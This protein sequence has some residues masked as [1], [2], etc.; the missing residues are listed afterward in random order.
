MKCLLLAAPLLLAPLVRA[1]VRVVAPT[2]APYAEIQAA[3][4]AASDGDVVLVKSGTYASFVIRNLSVAIVAD[5]GAVVDVEGSIRVS[6]VAATRTVVLAG[7]RATGTI[8]GS[9]STRHG[10]FARNCAGSLR[11][12]GCT[13]TG[14]P[15]NTG[16]VL[17]PSSHYPSPLPACYEGQGAYLEGC[18]DVALAGCA[19]SGSSAPATSGYFGHGTRPWAGI[20]DGGHGLY[21]VGS[22]V[23]VYDSTLQG[24][25]SGLGPAWGSGA[26]DPLPSDPLGYLGSAGEGL[27]ASSSF[28]FASSATLLGAA[29]WDMSCLDQCFCERPS[30][31]GNALVVDAPT[32]PAF[33]L[34]CV[35][36]P[37]AGGAG[38]GPFP[39]ACTCGIGG[40]FCPANVPAAPAGLASAGPVSTWS[41]FGRRVVL[42]TVARESAPFTVTFDGEPGDSVVLRM[43]ERTRFRF[44]VGARGVELV[45][46]ARAP[47]V[48]LQVG[49]LG[50]TGTRTETWSSPD[51]GAGVEARLLHL[52]AIFTDASGQ[53]TLSSPAAIV[54]LDASF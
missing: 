1:D 47:E 54:L 26:C 18:V 9:D 48:M 27:R 6:G 37:G 40:N 23:A 19:L 4:D 28:V 20:V 34:A 44:D 50:P 11:L 22:Q 13:L 42:P 46:R 45:R 41:G 30:A 17:P 29:G 7:L 8:S 14:V 3:V 12:Y 43:T 15:L 21:A 2:G 25:R 49:T 5:A 52:Q 31:G 24:G 38:S 36:L 16:I 32:G 10:L 39:P 53:R 35:L 51:L 33:E